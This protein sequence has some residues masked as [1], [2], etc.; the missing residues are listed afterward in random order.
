MQFLACSSVSQGKGEETG[1]GGE[2]VELAA[3]Q[4][5]EWGKKSI[6]TTIPV[7]G[8]ARRISHHRGSGRRCDMF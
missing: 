3:V 4:E 5:R 2:Q 8:K 6:K 1:A 7:N